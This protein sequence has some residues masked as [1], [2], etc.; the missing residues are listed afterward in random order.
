MSRKITRAVVVAVIMLVTAASQAGAVKRLPEALARSQTGAAVNQLPEVIAFDFSLNGAW[1]VNPSTPLAEN[2]IFADDGV[3]VGPMEWAPGGQMLGL[4]YTY[5]AD[6][7][8]PY[9]HGIKVVDRRGRVIGTFL[10]GADSNFSFFGSWSPDLTKVSYA[11]WMYEH[12]YT[13][14]VNE[15]CILDLKTGQ[16]RL[17]TDPNDY[18]LAEN[19]TGSTS[20]APDGKSILWD[21]GPVVEC[22]GT[23]Q[24]SSNEIVSVDAKS[25][26]LTQLTHYGLGPGYN[27]HVYGPSWSPDGQRIAFW[28][29][30]DHIHV[31]NADGGGDHVILGPEGVENESMRDP[32]WSPDGKKIVFSWSGHGAAAGN[33]DVFAMNPDGSG[34]YMHLTNTP[35]DDL[36]PTWAPAAPACTKMG[37]FGDDTIYGGDG[38]D[39]ICALGGDDKVY[40][41]GGADLI[42]GGAGNDIIVGAAGNDILEGEA[43][44]DTISGGGDND[45]L[46]GEAGNDTLT[47]G[48]GKDTLRG[49]DDEDILKAN[50]GVPSEIV[51]GGPDQDQCTADET[52]TLKSC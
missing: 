39:V 20:W 46:K 8:V 9:E 47:G 26:D 52:D 28:D 35:D 22:Y 7:S 38:N 2:P 49:G 36:F 45:S 37:T 48:G 43:G 41:K 21:G 31:M 44:R 4:S 5:G 51:D 29:N 15:V 32:S 42:F 23:E 3:R 16:G 27:F 24:C 12:G 50:D 19:G 17:L 6:G 40:G 13:V 1:T 14:P 33:N 34:P 10:N 25:G 11:C 18:I 30:G